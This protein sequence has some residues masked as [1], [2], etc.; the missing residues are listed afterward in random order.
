MPPL[1]LLGTPCRTI[2]EVG[3][4]ILIV[5]GGGHYAL[6]VEGVHFRMRNQRACSTRM[7]VWCTG[8]LRSQSL[9]FAHAI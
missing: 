1:E 3:S 5:G 9:D 8:L 6:L 7:I 2:F 4:V